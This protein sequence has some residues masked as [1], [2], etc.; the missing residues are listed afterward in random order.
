MAI[1][2]RLTEKLGLEHPIILAPMGIAASG[3]LAAAVSNAG[4]LGLVGI[5]YRGSEWI[6]EQSDAA[7]NVRVGFGFITWRLAEQ[8]DLLE[9]ALDRQPT[10]ICLSF[11]DPRPF[12]EQI[13]AAGVPLICQVQTLADAKAAV[14]ANA[15][16]V[17]AQGTEAGGYGGTR[18]TSTLVPEVADLLARI[19]ADTLL[20]A[21]GGIADG[22]GLAAALVLGA[23]GV[24]VGSR[25][26]ASEEANVHPKFHQTALAA[27][28]DST[29]RTTLMDIV[30]GYNWPTRYTN[31]ALKNSFLETWRGREAE[32]A[33]SVDVETAKWNK[34]WDEGDG[35]NSNVFISES[36]GL[37]KAIEPAACIIARMISDAEKRLASVTAAIR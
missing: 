23:D 8:P 12:A 1:R 29:I 6:K 2:T 16:I 28:G 20:C 27:D 37:I 10:A 5:G 19:S 34:A 4:G 25:F 31:R 15:S 14:E 24:L 32:L 3:K 33:A 22:R 17:V 9:L 26:W 21:A 35:E 18:S 11:G 36:V 30:R 13:L 7:A